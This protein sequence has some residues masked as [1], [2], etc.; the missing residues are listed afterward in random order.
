M[1]KLPGGLR[2]IERRRVAGELELL[3]HLL[4]AAVFAFEQQSQ[5]DFEF[6]DLRRL[7]LVAARCRGGAEERFKP[8]ARLRVFL[9]LERDLREIVMRLARVSGRASRPA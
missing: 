6:D 1:F 9:F 8:V 5:I 2:V 4:R 3:H 7:I